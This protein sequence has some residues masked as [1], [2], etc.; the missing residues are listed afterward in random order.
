MSETELTVSSKG[1]L[2][3]REALREARHDWLDLERGA[4]GTLI[5]L[6]LRP[7]RVMRAYLV[8]RRRDYVRPLRYLLFSV[9]LQVAVGWYVLNDPHLGK[10]LQGGAE[11]TAQASW[12]LEHAAVLTLMILPLVA[13]VLQLCMHRFGMRY[14]DALVVTSYTQA[15][16]NLF[17]AA[18]TVPV[19]LL[20]SP[21]FQGAVGIVALGYVV[22]AWASF[23][24]GRWPWR[25][26]AAL[27][28]V[29]LAQVLNGVVV[30][31]MTRLL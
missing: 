23:V 27:L 10:L 16:L 2:T 28:A 7:A 26:L 18:I 31:G 6:T 21:L 17:N 5:D 22:F 4:L 20:G 1:P 29:T 25:I 15:Q 13:G 30:W 8:E 19:V 14:V 11:T 24:E 9:A 3:L 12:F